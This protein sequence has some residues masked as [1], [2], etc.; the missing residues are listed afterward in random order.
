MQAALLCWRVRNMHSTVQ[1]WHYES[2]PQSH[3]HNISSGGLRTWMHVILGHS[4]GIPVYCNDIIHH[5]DSYWAHFLAAIY[6]RVWHAGCAGFGST[7]TPASHWLFEW[8]L[9]D[10]HKA[11]HDSSLTPYPLYS[12]RQNNN[13]NTTKTSVSVVLWQRCDVST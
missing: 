10:S 2:V 6:G 13:N 9:Y 1:H 11:T 7:I 3:M 12:H 5:W 8:V 4:Q